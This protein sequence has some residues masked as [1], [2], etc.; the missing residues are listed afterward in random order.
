LV[1][2]LIKGTINDKHRGTDQSKISPKKKP[3]E[4]PVRMVPKRRHFLLWYS[5]TLSCS[6]PPG[7]WPRSYSTATRA[8]DRPPARS[9]SWQPAAPGLKRRYSPRSRGRE[10]Q[11]LSRAGMFYDFSLCDTTDRRGELAGRIA[12]ILARI[13]ALV[14]SH[15]SW[16]IRRAPLK[17]EKRRLGLF[18]FCFLSNRSF[19][20]LWSVCSHPAVLIYDFQS[21]A[22]RLCQCLGRRMRHENS[23]PS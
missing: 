10:V 1:H 21:V 14:L 4:L 18:I 3:Q 11:Q 23:G 20:F 13:A 5:P 16:V 9:E 17:G 12:H 7:T 19:L 8:A 6:C 2:Q 22:E 15:S